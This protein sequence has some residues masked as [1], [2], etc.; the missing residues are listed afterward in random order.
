MV[1]KIK[2]PRIPRKKL[3][4]KPTTPLVTEKAIVYIDPNCNK[5]LADMYC[6]KLDLPLMKYLFDD[7]QTETSASFNNYYNEVGCKSITKYY[8]C[9]QL[10][11]R[12]KCSQ[13]MAKTFLKMETINGKCLNS[14][15]NNKIFLKKNNSNKL[16]FSSNNLALLNGLLILSFYF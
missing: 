12:I 16:T 13:T 5:N 8:Q 11:F 15:L 7:S 9:L 6:E 2:L 4:T 1:D 3:T 14:N 10:N